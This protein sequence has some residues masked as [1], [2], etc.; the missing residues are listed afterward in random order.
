MTQYDCELEMDGSEGQIDIVEND[1]FHSSSILLMYR[2]H[3][4]SRGD[5]VVRNGLAE[6]DTS[7]LIHQGCT[8][9]I[10]PGFHCHHNW[11][12]GASAGL[13]LVHTVSGIAEGIVVEDN[14]V[15]GEPNACGHGHGG[16]GMM[17]ADDSSLF[18]RNSVLRRNSVSTP[19]RT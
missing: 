18:L 12:T 8:F 7:V 11:A 15:S 13:L 4:T 14:F 3:L 1:A 5:V 19:T 2:G 6:T 9:E 10:Y 17:F 16:G